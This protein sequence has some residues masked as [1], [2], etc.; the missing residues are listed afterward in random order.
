MRVFQL[1]ITQHPSP[2]FI[3]SPAEIDLVVD[4]LG[5]AIDDAI[6]RAGEH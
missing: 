4:R 1:I 5:T 2:P 3:I 6:S